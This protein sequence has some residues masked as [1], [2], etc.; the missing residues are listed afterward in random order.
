MLQEKL[1]S[2]RK[3]VISTLVSR[4]ADKVSFLG[5]AYR[6]FKDHH[7]ANEIACRTIV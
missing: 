2:A 4:Q 6:S 7:L 3:H 5:A 1:L